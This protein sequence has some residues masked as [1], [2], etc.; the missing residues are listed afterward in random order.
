MRAIDRKLLRDLGRL[1]GQAAAIAL[2]IAAGVMT[3]IIAVTTYDAL[4]HTQQRF[5]TEHHF[6]DVFADLKRA[7][8]GVIERLRLMPGVNQIETRVRAPVR[9]A[10]A[11]FDE[12]V[13]GVLLSLPDGRQPT[14]NRLFLR[15]GSLPESGRADQVVI[16]D[17]FAEAHGLRPGDALEAIVDGRLIRLVVSGVA[18][19][20]EFVYQSAPT[21]LL[22]DYR[23]YGIVWMNRRALAR[24]YGMDGAFNSVVVSLQAGAREADVIEA[25]ELALGR[26]GLVVAHGRYEQHSHRFLYEE[27][28]QL[29]AQALIMPTIFMLVSAFLLNVVMSRIIR[30]QREQVAVL[31]AFGYSNREIATHYG[32]LTGLIVLLG[33][34]AGIALGA[35]ASG[36]MGALYEAYFRFPEIHFRVQPWAM[37]LALIV[38]GGAAMLGTGRAVWR[39]V[40]QP[41]AEAM[42]PEP[43]P[44]FRRGWL[45]RSALGRLIDA[46]SRIIV[47]NLSRH[48][49]K[50]G[51]SVAGIGMSVGLLVMG[52]YQL[53]A[54][55]HMIDTQY[56][57]V[58][59][60]DV[61]LTFGNPLPARVAGELR[62]LPGVLAVETYRSVPVRLIAGHRSRDTSILGLPP[63]PQL[64]RLLDARQQPRSPPPEGLLLTDYLAHELGLAVGD[65][66]QVEVLEG[67]RRVLAIALAGVV[68][69]PIGVSA[70]MAR[71]ALNRVMR[72]GAA[73]S[74]AWL[75]TD[76]DREAELFAEL[77]RLPVVVGIGLISEAERGI[78]EYMGDTMQM[79]AVVFVLLAGSIAFAVVYNN[80]RITFA[81][82]AREL[83]TL[84]VLGYSR[85]QVSWILIGEIALLTALALPLGWAV[86]TGFCWAINQAFSQDLFRVPLV[87]TPRAY[88]FAT[89]SVLAAS[90]LAGLMMVRRLGSLD[91]VAVLKAVE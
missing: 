33:W 51:L 4:Y 14:L 91:K 47:R 81:E 53:D 48:P 80:A 11:G 89:A 84:E 16:S 58:Q 63:E 31:K 29:R 3:L 5:Y 44:R 78:R 18:L 76:R 54:V 19:S 70:Y 49:L 17:A 61:H 55:D 34:A 45:E 50:S 71:D 28:Q 77:D 21:D 22:P 10:V 90:V 37:A 30:T 85:L 12:P 69:E 82:R 87:L 83:A 65:V 68:D 57:S 66:V 86:G 2:V 26:Y 62:H 23:R 35:W 88:G 1:K 41:P 42:R 38:A 52:A 73:V 32:M 46:P 7:P 39:A 27:L 43:P 8:E 6:A 36:G 56:G 24:A 40:R 67:N 74:G 20:P 60:M 79:F 64:R 72:E 13:R 9:L 15:E 75:L 25:L 59:R